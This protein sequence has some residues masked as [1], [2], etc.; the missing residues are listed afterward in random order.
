VN[1]SIL[2]KNASQRKKVMANDPTNSATPAGNGADNNQNGTGANQNQNGQGTQNAQGTQGQTP[3]VFNPTDEQWKQIFAHPR[4]KQLDER[5]TNAETA[6]KAKTDAEE[7]ARQKK[8]KE[9]GDLAKLLEEKEG[10]VTTLSATVK[11]LRIENKMIT[12]ASKLKVLDTDAV[13]KLVD[14]SK[15]KFDKD[16][17]PT[18][19]EDVVKEL[20]TEKPY[21]VGEGGNGSST[22]GAGSNTTTGNQG[23]GFIITKSQLKENLKDHKWYEENKDK[24][25][26]WQKQGRIDYSK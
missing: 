11:Q 23:E 14:T 9:D 21:L 12:I 7:K 22:I 16:E 20:L 5:A 13:I 10:S 1:E 25:V 18:N 3:E 19:L 15:I 17:N 2:A 24:I 6:L 4:F 26:E 8:L